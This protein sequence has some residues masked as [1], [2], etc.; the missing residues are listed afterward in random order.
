MKAKAAILYEV[1]TPLRIE[2]IDIDDPKDEEVLV[3]LSATGVCHSDIHVIK[4]DIPAFM[5]VVLG[6]E[7]AGIVEKVGKNVTEVKPGD[8]VVLV[9]TPHCGKCAACLTGKPYICERVM[10]AGMGGTMM[11][12]TSRMK[13]DGEPLHHY[14][15]QSSFSQYCVAEEE[16]VVKVPDDVPLDV[17]CLLSCGSSTGIG[18]VLNKAKVEPGD[19]VA[20]I[21]CGGVGLSAV[22]AA[23]LIGASRIFAVDKL[24]NKLQM[25][26]ELGATDLV[27][28]SK[29]D[30]LEKI[31]LATMGGVDYV[32]EAIGNADTIAMAFNMLKYGGTAVVVGVAPWGAL[33]S[34]DA[35]FLLAEKSLTGCIA[36]RL[37]P[38]IDIPRYV[39]LFK[40]GR[41]PLDKLVT[42]RYPLEK[43]NDAI[44]ATLEGKVIRAVITF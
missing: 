15:C 7:G 42:A 8:K 29:E 32:I 4:G 19:S 36:G 25:A 31:Q 43:I 9:V 44:Q 5:P 21:G 39:D 23:H 22:M 18:A 13:K 37:R 17:V 14:F 10:D 1:D 40:A 27:N 34:I 3:K 26:Q 28:A 24:E 20:I 33:V 6:H 35:M 11:D 30:P 12:G 41:L 16:V 2:E 38:R